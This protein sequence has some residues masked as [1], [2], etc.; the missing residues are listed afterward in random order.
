MVRR[1]GFKILWLRYI[2][3]PKTHFQG[4]DSEYY[5]FVT[6]TYWYPWLGR[7]GSKY[8][9]CDISNTHTHTPQKKNTSRVEI[10]NTM[11]VS[12]DVPIVADYRLSIVFSL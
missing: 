12:S 10:Q 4:G 5:G 8:Y 3:P 1:R 11:V 7:G 9:G 2:E 6:L